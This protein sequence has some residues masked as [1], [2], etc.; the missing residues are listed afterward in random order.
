[1]AFLQQRYSHSPEQLLLLDF[2]KY[3]AGTTSPARIAQAAGK[4]ATGQ[5][6]CPLARHGE[7]FAKSRPVILRKASAPLRRRDANN[8]STTTTFSVSLTG[9]LSSEVSYAGE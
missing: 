5:V 2:A 3:G 7:A 6:T 1:M 4:S 9:R 8:Q